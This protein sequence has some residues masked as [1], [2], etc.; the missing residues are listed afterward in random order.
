MAGKGREANYELLR[1]LAM[2]MVV[3]M[4][5]LERSNSLLALDEPFNGLDIISVEKAIN[6][7]LLCRKRG[8]TVILTSHQ[9]DISSRA[10]DTYY[11]LKIKRYSTAR[12]RKK[13]QAT[14]I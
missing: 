5:F 9:L 1:V 11:L 3:A 7:L 2:V 14:D 8:A 6:L 10:V 13:A 12:L 4:H